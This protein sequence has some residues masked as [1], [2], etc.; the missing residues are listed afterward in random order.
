MSEGIRPAARIP[1]AEPLRVQPMREQ[2]NQSRR[3]QVKRSQPH[4]Q[5]P[6]VPEAEEP[7]HAADGFA[8]DPV[9]Q[10]LDVEI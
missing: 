1:P 4:R 5:L 9:P 10:Q 6:P 7:L 2:S 3:E 8:L